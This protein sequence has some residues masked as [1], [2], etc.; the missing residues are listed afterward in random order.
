MNSKEFI[1]SEEEKAELS[2]R[3]KD[4]SFHNNIVDH[5]D[6]SLHD[7]QG[8]LEEYDFFVDQPER[9]SEICEN[10]LHPLYSKADTFSYSDFQAQLAKYGIE[11]PDRDPE[12]DKIPEQAVSDP[13]L[14]STGNQPSGPAEKEPNAVPVEP[15]PQLGLTPEQKER[16]DFDIQRQ[17]RDLTASAFSNPHALMGQT[18]ARFFRLMRNL[19]DNVAL[20]KAF[21]KTELGP[22]NVP[23]VP[24]TSGN[25][26]VNE[27]RMRMNSF[28]VEIKSGEIKSPETIIKGIDEFQSQIRNTVSS[29]K[30]FSENDRDIVRNSF[31]GLEDKLKEKGFDS[32]SGISKKMEE[33]KKAMK[34]L[35]ESLFKKKSP[36]KDELTPG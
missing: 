30:D 1:L 18:G 36:P 20:G 24:N 21:K 34:E 19:W 23:G 35:F 27:L 8:H 16:L 15:R 12:L 28:G 33:A 9:L 6:R 17:K 13:L 11:L 10:V 14:S 4:F 31:K 22:I 32:D 25:D 5:I 2:E 7:F 3:F 29:T 26:S